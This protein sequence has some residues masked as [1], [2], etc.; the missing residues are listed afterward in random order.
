MSFK[1]NDTDR[2]SWETTPISDSSGTAV[3]ID[4]IRGNINTDP[5]LGP[6]N[7]PSGSPYAPRYPR[8]TEPER[9]SA[10]Y[11]IAVSRA[12]HDLIYDWWVV[13]RNT[14]SA[15]VKACRSLDLLD[16]YYDYEW[17]VVLSK[18]L[19]KEFTV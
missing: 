14:E 4:P 13:A 7:V 19:S 5:C 12:D 1:L 17:H 18:E 8:V 16:D 15:K 3:W 2:A 6:Y 10:Y 9:L 11:V